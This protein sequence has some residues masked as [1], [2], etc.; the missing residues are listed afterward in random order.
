MTD[1][2]AAV[3]GGAG[4]GALN[5]FG[6]VI[7]AVERFTSARRVWHVALLALV[8]LAQA[9]VLIV[10]VYEREML[11]AKG[12][13]IALDVVPVDPR[14]LFRGD[15]VILSYDISRVPAAMLPQ[16]VATGDRVRVAIVQRDGKWTVAA[17]APASAPPPA[18]DAGSGGVVLRGIVASMSGE[19]WPNGTVVMRYGIESFFVPEGS[20]RAIEQQVGARKVVAHVAVR[21]DGTAA[22]KGLSIDGER[23]EAPPL[24]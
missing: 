19:T 16:G 15:Y 7:R 2:M 10:M 3:D 12:R 14:S 1:R 21:G 8:A 23:I 5:S 20:G 6:A 22:I 4:N 17:V 11:L 18:V 13:E 24:L 9:A